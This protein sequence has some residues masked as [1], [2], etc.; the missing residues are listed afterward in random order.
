MARRR[1]EEKERS[2]VLQYDAVNEQV[3]IAACLVED[4]SRI[5]ILSK[6]NDA[7]IFQAPEHRIIYANILEMKRRNLEFDLATL[8]TMAGSEYPSDYVESLLE[9]RP[10]APPNLAYHVD[11]L[12]WDCTRLRAAIGSVSSFLDALKNPKEQRERVVSLAKQVGNSFDDHNLEYIANPE[13]LV[14]AQMEDIENRSKG[15]NRTPFGI[16]SLDCFEDGSPRLLPG[17]ARKMTTVITGLSGA[18]KTSLICQ[19]LLEQTRLKKKILLGAWEEDGGKMLEN[20]AALSMGLSRTKRTTGNLTPEELETLH[21]R[22]TVISKYVLI[23]RNPF[24]REKGVRQ[25]NETNLDLIQNYIANTGCDIFVADLWRRCLVQ[26]DPEDEELAFERQQ[27]IARE[28]NIHQI[29]LH[30]LRSKDVEQRRD[31]R[32]TREAMKGSGIITEAPDTI[33]GI[34]RPGQWN[35]SIPDDKVEIY[36]LKQRHGKWPLAIEFDHN[37]DIGKIERGISIEYKTT[38]Q[39]ERQDGATVPGAPKK[40]GFLS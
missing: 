13:E 24:K 28:Q 19:I 21:Y 6:I 9:A 33:L 31:K 5:F 11:T 34:H 15:V 12:L 29:I 38:E 16:P 22:M 32:P 39:T 35:S 40:K 26:R 8:A 23:L 37:P 17:M 1:V 36:V 30:Q 10:D 4:E 25:Y 14:R 20:I 3:I 7:G 18:G 2:V 27:Q